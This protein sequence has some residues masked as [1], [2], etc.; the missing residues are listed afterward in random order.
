MDL[1]GEEASQ[2]KVVDWSMGKEGEGVWCV[3]NQ[4]KF[5]CEGGVSGEGVRMVDCM[6]RWVGLPVCFVDRVS[7]VGGT[8]VSRRLEVG[9]EGVGRA[10]MS[11]VELVVEEVRETVSG[12]IVGVDEAD[13]EFGDVVEAFEVGGD[14]LVGVESSLRDG[15]MRAVGVEVVCGA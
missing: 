3:R 13:K 2:G 11:E 8:R 9:V 5:V 1:G 15:R 4:A 7:V 14:G 6:E 12:C 10:I